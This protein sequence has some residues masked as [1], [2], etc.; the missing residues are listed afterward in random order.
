MT[1]RAIPVTGITPAG[2]EVM[3][4]LQAKEVQ[5]DKEEV[6][7]G[8]GVNTLLYIQALFTLTNRHVSC[9]HCKRAVILETKKVS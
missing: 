6:G 9:W 2:Q 1:V 8:K 3:G 4:V 7:E 5:E